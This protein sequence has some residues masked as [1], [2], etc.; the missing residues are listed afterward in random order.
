MA[1]FANEAEVYKYIGGVF[2]KGGE[3]PE[4]GAKLAGAGITAQLHYSDP[5]SQLTV[6]FKEP[7]EVIEGDTDEKA[8]IHLYM[9]ADDADK[10]WR[11]E[12]NLAVALAKGHVKAKGPVNKLLK[13]VPAA[14]PL[15]PMYKDIVREKDEAGAAA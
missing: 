1:Y 11:G 5:D 2:R 4:V 10:F 12:L 13:L 7:I 3:H 15:F 9:R 8:D 14:K 6:K